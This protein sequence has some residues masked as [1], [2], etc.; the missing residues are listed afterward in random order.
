MLTLRE[1]MPSSFGFVGIGR[2]ASGW[3]GGATR[4]GMSPLHLADDLVADQDG[5]G[6]D[7]GAGRDGR[8]GDV[9]AG[10]D[11]DV[12]A[13]VRLVDDGPGADRH[14][15]ADGVGRGQGAAQDDG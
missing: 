8:A 9:G 5:S 7:G 2:V 15:V 3:E 6:G 14:V 11:G 10:A 1:S 13:E 12:V 4:L